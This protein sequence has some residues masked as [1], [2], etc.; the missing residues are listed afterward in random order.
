MKQSIKTRLDKLSA[1]IGGSGGP[2]CLCTMRDG[3]K[4][5][6]NGYT[7]LEPRLSGDILDM[8]TEDPNYY[9]FFAGLG[10]E[11]VKITLVPRIL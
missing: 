8:K 5:I 6:M 3:K 4:R 11:G 2:R 9:N 10:P 7:A 1:K